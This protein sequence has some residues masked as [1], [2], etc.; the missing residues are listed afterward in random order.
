MGGRPGSSAAFPRPPRAL[1]AGPLRGAAC[2][3][4]RSP[5][6]STPPPPMQTPPWARETRSEGRLSCVWEKGVFLKGKRW[7]MCAQSYV[8]KNHVYWEIE[9]RLK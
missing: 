4:T 1:G 7:A 3:R 6:E 5:G 9:P 8:F 2:V